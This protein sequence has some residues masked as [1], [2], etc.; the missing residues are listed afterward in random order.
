MD[1][2]D[3]EQ[4]MLRFERGWWRAAGAKEQ[5]IRERFDLTATAYYQVLNAL[6]DRPEA[7]AF[8]PAFEPA[9]V[10]R[11]QRIRGVRRSRQS[12]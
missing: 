4:A 1:L 8:E 5:E 7:L 2:T 12:A 9:V 3:T 11:L 10:R 6:I